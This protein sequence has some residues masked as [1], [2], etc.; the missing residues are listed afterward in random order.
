ML[1]VPPGTDVFYFDRQAVEFIVN[2][3]NPYGHH[4]TEIPSAL[5]TPGAESV[6]PYL[7]FTA[8]YLVPFY[9]TGD[10]RVGFIAADVLIG[11]VLYRLS[12]EA[13]TTSLIYWFIPFTVI[14]STVY[15]NNSLISL[16]FIALFV[17]LEK[18]GR[19]FLGALSFGLALS[20]TQ[21][22]W[23]LLPFILYNY[24]RDWRWKES[25]LAVL[26]A[27]VVILP[28]FIAG[29]ANFYN[30]IIAFQFTRQTLS[31]VTT[32]GPLGYN[33]NLSLNGLLLTF[34]NFTLPGAV[35]LLLS[36]AL[37]P[38]F[39]LR[40]KNLERFLIHTSGYL[41]LAVFI[42]PNDF[43]WAYTELPFFLFL[44]YLSLFQGKRS[45]GP[46]RQ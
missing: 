41:F 2:L 22:A 12:S 37:L 8:L 43:F 32:A 15:V 5:E 24:L 38:L 21:F 35:R 1:N 23:L 13:K 34:L 20:A 46:S 36:A 31:L 33:V 4:F 26:V 18:L 40:A 29:P 9:F 14:F 39:A 10:I 30:D 16:P 42:L 25:A 45:L 11:V 3:Q 7:P 27:L 6:F 19:R 17:L 28:F 44:A